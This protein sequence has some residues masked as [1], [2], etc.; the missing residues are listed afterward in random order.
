LIET[1]VSYYG[2]LFRDHIKKDIIELVDHGVTSIVLAVSEY[3][4]SIWVDRI[5]EII[6]LFKYYGLKVYWDFWAWGKVFGGE[7]TSEYLQKNIKHRQVRSN[8]EIAPAACFNDRDFVNYLLVSIDQVAEETEIDGFFWDEPSFYNLPQDDAWAC[9]CKVCQT[10]FKEE[11]GYPMP[12]ELND[13]VIKFRE[14][15][16]LRFLQELLARVKENNEKL[17]NIICVLPEKNP[18]IGI[19][20]WD[21]I[22]KL[23]GLDVLSSDPY[24]PIFDKSFE[25]YKD[26]TTEIKSI[27]SRY[28]LESQIWLQLFMLPENEVHRLED[29]IVFAKEVGI[30]S[31]FAWPF[32][33]AE[34]QIIASENPEKTWR[35]LGKIYKK[36]KMGE[37]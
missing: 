33:A 22:A 31:I 18:K 17:K 21:K 29:A 35:I 16:I 24:W 9:L 28:N 4:M 34:G 1:G 37:I 11:F 15:S 32:R 10:K 2:C 8:G 7:A 36:L 26:V 20:N 27:A 5:K 19:I 6:E 23:S 30:N 12:K 3:E 13:D 25:W 14:E